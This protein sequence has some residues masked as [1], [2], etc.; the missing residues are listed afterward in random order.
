[1]VRILFVDDEVEP[2]L[3]VIAV[4]NAGGHDC[5]VESD[6][7]A[8]L[9]YLAAH[10]IDLVVTDIMMPPGEGHPEIPSEKTGLFFIRELRARYGQLPIAC[11]SVIGR[12]DIIDEVRSSGVLYLQKGS[13]SLRNVVRL[14]EAHA[15]S[16]R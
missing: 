13:T 15:G 5:H 6:M 9:Q 8:A 4:L 10:R 14:L 7:Q 3:G 1:M 16:A 11:L 2:L 12:Q